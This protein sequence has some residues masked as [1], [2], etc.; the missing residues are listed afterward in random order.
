MIGQIQY[1]N[2]RDRLA[3]R[4]IV[5]IADSGGDGP[6]AR[7]PSGIPRCGAGTTATGGIHGARPAPGHS[8]R[9]RRPAGQ[10]LHRR[11]E[12]HDRRGC[13]HRDLPDRWAHQPGDHP[14]RPRAQDRRQ[15]P[16]ERDHFGFEVE[17]V[18]DTVPLCDKWGAAKRVEKRPPHREAEFRVLD[19]D[20]NPID[21]SAHGWP[22]WRWG[23][24]RCGALTA[25]SRLYDRR[26]DT[27]RLPGI[28]D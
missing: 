18:A 1:V 21:L 27:N 8:H 4:K 15:S 14:D 20:G 24:S 17:N 26:V 23:R 7:L 11:V 12:A 6:R 10:V 13:R 3:V 22:H 5:K 25:R 2:D 19:P 9:G 28:L 16:E